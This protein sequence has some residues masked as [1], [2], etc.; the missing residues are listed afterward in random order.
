MVAKFTLRIMKGSVIM[1][2]T[3]I[4][5][6]AIYA[7][8]HLLEKLGKETETKKASEDGYDVYFSF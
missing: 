8:I 2:F 4:L 5:L 1:L 7:C 6:S 3:T